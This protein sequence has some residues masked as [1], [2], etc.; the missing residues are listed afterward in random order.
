MRRLPGRPVVSFCLFVG[1]WGLLTHLWAVLRGIVDPLPMLRSPGPLAAV[2]IA[3][4]EFIFYGCI[5]LGLAALRQEGRG[6]VR[7]SI[8]RQGGAA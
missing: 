6:R 5:L 4:L 2:V 8:W 7:R 1:A 3:V